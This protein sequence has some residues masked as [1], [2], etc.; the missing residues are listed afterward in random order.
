M[1]EFMNNTKWKL[2]GGGLVIVT[3]LVWLA[4]SGF[5]ES[6]AYY[7]TVDELLSMK[8]KSIVMRVRFAGDL[9]PGSVEQQGDT[10]F[11]RLIQNGK[12]VRVRYIGTAV[13]PDSFKEGTQAI[14]E[15]SMSPEGLFL[16]RKVQAKSASKYEAAPATDPESIKGKS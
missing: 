6:S 11:F 15:G 8:E 16:A 5:E 4:F 7:K 2:M 12:A 13:L 14:C 1:Q 9:V 10:V 3:V